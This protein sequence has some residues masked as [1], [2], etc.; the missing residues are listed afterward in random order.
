MPIDK[1]KTKGSDEDETLFIIKDPDHL[2]L[3]S[4]ICD[5]LERAEQLGFSLERGTELEKLTV[6]ELDILV[7]TVN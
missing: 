7:N 1:L 2:Y 3:H 6:R 5:L 4:E